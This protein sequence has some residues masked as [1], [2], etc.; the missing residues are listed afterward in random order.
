MF[1]ASW[2]ALEE[3]IFNIQSPVRGAESGNLQYL[4]ATVWLYMYIEYD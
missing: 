4:G 3:G 1:E 2:L